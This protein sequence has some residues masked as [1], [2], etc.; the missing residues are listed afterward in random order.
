MTTDNAL[1]VLQLAVGVVFLLSFLGKSAHLRGF[2]GGVQAYHV[3]PSRFTTGTAIL[4][5]AWELARAVT[6]ITGSFLLAASW[7][8]IAL[9]S[10]FG[11]TVTIILRR[12]QKVSCYCFGGEEDVISHETVLRLLSMLVA[13]VGVVASQLR[14]TEAV[15]SP[16]A[17]RSLQDYL[18][19]VIWVAILLQ[20]MMWLLNIPSIVRLASKLYADLSLRRA[21]GE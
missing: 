19:A 11:V 17:E 21:L 1:W 8:G 12:Q 5:V 6:H 7:A 18:G 4:I 14:H 10:V 20:G 13:E 3:V 9:L 16:Y 2:I 15:P